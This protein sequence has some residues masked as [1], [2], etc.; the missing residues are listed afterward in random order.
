MPWFNLARITD[1]LGFTKKD[2]YNT[3]AA[4]ADF[5]FDG[6]IDILIQLNVN[7]GVPVESFFLINSGL[8]TFFIDNNFPITYQTTA[9]SSRKTI[10]GDFNGDGKPD[11]VRPQG[12]HDWLGKPTITLSQ[13]DNS[14]VFKLIGNGPEVQPHTLSS[15]DIDSDGDLDIFFAQ[16]G[17]FDGLIN[18]GNANFTW[19]WI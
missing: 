3:N 16:A 5:N 4:Y 7:D 15:G 10:V 2:S 11:V 6:Y 14:Y 1:S 18:D 9:I 19:K 17:E 12:G 8:N 13:E